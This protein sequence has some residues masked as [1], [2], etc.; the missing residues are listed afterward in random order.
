MGR[1]SLQCD[2]LLR[3][4]QC[5]PAALKSSVGEGTRSPDDGQE[6][7]DVRLRG[8]AGSTSTDRGFLGLRTQQHVEYQVKVRDEGEGAS[9]SKENVGVR[10]PSDERS[11]GFVIRTI[12]GSY[13]E[14][15]V[16]V[17]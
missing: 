10:R 2:C 9:P 16:D 15:K 5:V 7:P 17:N 6:L 12:L 8:P 11:E 4:L 13:H 14:F 3:L 1:A